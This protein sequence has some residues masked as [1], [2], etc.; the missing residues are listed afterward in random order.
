MERFSFDDSM[1]FPGSARI[2][3]CS[4]Q[5]DVVLGGGAVVANECTPA[6]YARRERDAKPLLTVVSAVSVHVRIGRNPS[7][8]PTR[9]DLAV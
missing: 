9:E 8:F 7:A 4:G 1:S 5:R 2:S 3:V 6:G